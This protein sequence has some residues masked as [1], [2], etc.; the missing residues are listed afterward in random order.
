MLGLTDALESSFGRRFLPTFVDNS[1]VVWS[2]FSPLV[3]LK[4]LNPD[5]FA[6]VFLD[7]ILDRII[8]ILAILEPLAFL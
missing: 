4:T 3:P 1:D 8:L 7:L 5:D 2:L 6:Q